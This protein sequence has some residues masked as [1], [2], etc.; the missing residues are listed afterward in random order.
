VIKKNFIYLFLALFSSYAISEKISLICDPSELS[1][2]EIIN[3]DLISDGIKVIPT[4]A[5]F[6]KTDSYSNL[7]T[8][9]C[10]K[11]VCAEV[12]NRKWCKDP[13]ESFI[14]KSLNKDNSIIIVSNRCDG[15]FKK[16]SSPIKGEVDYP[17]KYLEDKF[18]FQV[19][20][21]IHAGTG[22]Q[23]S[24]VIKIDKDSEGYMVTIKD[25]TEDDWDMEWTREDISLSFFTVEE[26]NAFS[27]NSRCVAN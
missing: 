19:K 10:K 23:R 22:F 26:E 7:T 21:Q 11:S 3:K 4:F 15:G 8:K 20:N 14:I 17:L 27:F 18:L 2:L 24:P 16:F 9:D 6:L 13:K 12:F 25:F 1:S 5:P